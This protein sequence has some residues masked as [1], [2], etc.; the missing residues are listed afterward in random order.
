VP[1]D[2]SSP[3]SIHIIGIGGAGMSAIATVLLQMGHRVSGSDGVEAVTTERL[4]SQGAQVFIGHAASNVPDDV[5]AVAYSTAIP[6]DNPERERAVSLGVPVLR[7]AEILR[8]IASLKKTLAVAGT[9]GKTTTSTLLAHVMEA[10]GGGVEPSW[11]I[12]GEI[13]GKSGG[14][15]WGDGEVFVVEADESDGTFVELGAHGVIVTNV[16]PDHLEF[17][18]SLDDRDAAFGAL[19]ATFD[20]FVAEAPGPKVIC[21]DDEGGAALAGRHREALTY[22]TG[23]GAAYR[24]LDVELDRFSAHFVVA[25]QSDRIGVEIH[26]PGM[27]N[28]RNATAA[29]ALGHQMGVPL[30]IGAVGLAAFRGVGRRFTFR[31]ERNGITFVDEYAH[32]PG[33]VRA[34][35]AAAKAGRWGRVVAVFQ[36]HRYSRTEQ[37]GH[38]FTG[39]FDDADVLVLADVYAAGEPARPGIDGH[40]VERAVRAADGHPP[41]TYVEDR[42]DLA[43]SV[44]VMLQPGDLCLTLG[45]GDITK[46]SDETLSFLKA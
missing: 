42:S 12:G 40:V 20:R 45:A 17:Y 46:L 28:V 19:T 13:A 22:G 11:I 27:H 41:I 44:A 3:R 1:I 34:A 39:A 5:D 25:H 38:E 14:A 33:E 2:L 4:R 9:H 8:A 32:L 23:E 30:D 31:G 35:L 21:A 29:L 18:G 24:I 43:R 7:R 10:G 37:V 15:Q 16:E 36:P 26:I 6:A